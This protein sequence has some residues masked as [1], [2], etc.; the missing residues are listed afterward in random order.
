MPEATAVVFGEQRL[1]YRELNERANKLARYLQR[2]GVGPKSLVGI[3]IERSVEMIVGLLGILKAGGAYVPLDTSYPQERIAL[4][5]DDAR[6]EVL[7]TQSNQLNQVPKHK[8]KVVCLDRDWQEIDRE[9]GDNFDANVSADNAAY[10]IYTSGSTG[11]PKG[12]VVS[13]QNVLRLF[14]ATKS[15]F[16]FSQRDVWTLFHSYAFDFSVWELWGALVHG[17]RLVIVPYFVSRTPEAFRELLHREG[18]TVL[19]QTPSAFR[20]LMFVEESAGEAERLNL[21]LVIFG[22]E[23]LEPQTLRPWLERY[24]DERPQLVNMYGITETTVHVTYR[25]IR[26]ADLESGRR[27]VIGD[28]ILDL[29]VYVLDQYQQPV[30]VGVA[31]ELCV[32]GDGLARGYLHQPGLTAERFLPDPFG[33]SAGARLYRSGDLVRQLSDSEIEYLGRIDQQVKIRGFR[34][35]PGE[36]EAT[37]N[38]HSAVRESVVIAHEEATGDKRLVAYFVAR[39]SESFSAEDLRNHLQQR[40]P[41]FMLPAVFVE[42]K[43]LP[44]TLNGK[45]DRRA[46]PTPEEVA[47]RPKQSFAA[48]RGEAER[49]LADIWSEVLGIKPVGIN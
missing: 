23:A 39:D 19:N 4:M 9:R 13:H 3:C 42:L 41:D 45:I 10:V 16:D 22:G 49:I 25:R 40:L 46:L 18:V 32:A 11:Q 27:S 38:E 28:A 12:V 30:P 44:L 29:H 17:G 33:S 24:G 34:V 47:V 48:P 36:I 8:A 37:L 26:M 7:V 14:D 1:S 5:L 20:Q 2:L 21:R 15:W 31:G 6:V 43:A 35:E